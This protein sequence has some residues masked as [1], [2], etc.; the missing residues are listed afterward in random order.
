M[1][2]TI[3]R[4]APEPATSR[5]AVHF[6]VVLVL[7]GDGE[8]SRYTDPPFSGTLATLDLSSGDLLEYPLQGVTSAALAPDGLA[9]D[10]IR[11]G[12]VEDRPADQGWTFGIIGSIA[13]GA[14]AGLV[15]WSVPRRAALRPAGGTRAGRGAG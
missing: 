12:V 9:R 1:S 10:L 14:A 5:L 8:R 7:L 3:A 4:P 15:V 11:E 13:V 2:T 6:P